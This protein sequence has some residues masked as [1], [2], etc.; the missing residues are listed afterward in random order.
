VL[1]FCAVWFFNCENSKY[2]ISKLLASGHSLLATASNQKQEASGQLQE[3]RR[4]TLKIDPI[5]Q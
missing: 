4:L 3:A 5:L 2:Q 1:L